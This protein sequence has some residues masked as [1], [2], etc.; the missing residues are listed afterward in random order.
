[1]SVSNNA[2]SKCTISVTLLG[3]TFHHFL[4]LFLGCLPPASS[5]L[6]LLSAVA[7]SEHLPSSPS[8]L[9]SPGLPLVGG[10]FCWFVCLNRSLG[11][12]F[13]TVEAGGI[14]LEWRDV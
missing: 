14:S 12:K 8:L 5:S 3:I 1:M 13:L 2:H 4:G 11:W 6:M 7:S 10:W 9:P